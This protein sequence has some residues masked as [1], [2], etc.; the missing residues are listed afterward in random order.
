MIF[1]PID[2]P[3][4]GKIFNRGSW[5]RNTKIINELAKGTSYENSLYNI[6]GKNYKDVENQFLLW[7]DTKIY[8]KLY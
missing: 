1:G 8:D 3:S 6:L 2:F 7:Y 5:W 4:K